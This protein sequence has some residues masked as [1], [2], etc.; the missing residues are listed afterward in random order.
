MDVVEPHQAEDR[1][2]ARH[3]P[4]AFERLWVMRLRRG[5]EM[6]F[7]VPDESI[8]VVDQGQIDCDVFLHR[9]IGKALG[10][11]LTRHFGRERLASRRHIGLA[12]RLPNMGQPLRSLAHQMQAAPQQV[13]GGTH[14]GRIRRGLRQHAAPQSHGN[15]LGVET[16]MLG[17]AAV[18]RLHLLGV[19]QHQR[20][21]LLD[22]QVGK[23]VPR[24]HAFHGHHEILA[25]RS[26]GL[27]KGL[28]G[29]WHIPVAHDLTVSV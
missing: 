14:R 7:E 28:R 17:L 21:T 4:Q 20:Q 8:I 9:W 10:N 16:I 3:R 18:D 1:A 27:A 22:A 19:S 13:A 6:V 5:H 23:P 25:I 24:K 26:N 11:C 29:G 12:V 2:N 15:L